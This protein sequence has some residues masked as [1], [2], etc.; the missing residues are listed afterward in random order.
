MGAGAWGMG[1]EGGETLSGTGADGAIGGGAI[2]DVRR[3]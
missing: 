2:S 3:F 1:G